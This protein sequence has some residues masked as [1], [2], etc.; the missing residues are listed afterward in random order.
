MSIEKEA[1]FGTWLYY[2]ND[3][4]KARW[5]CS[6]C[7]KIIR[8]GAHEKLYCSHCGAKMKPES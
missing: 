2:I 4:G 6:E 8:H 3:E 1:K 7:G 5:K